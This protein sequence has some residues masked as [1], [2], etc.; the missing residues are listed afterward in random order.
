MVG[1]LSYGAYIPIWRISRD[2]IARASGGPSMGGERSVASW[3]EDSLTMAVEAGLDCLTGIDPKEVDGVYFATVSSPFREKQA[4]SMIATALDLRKDVYTSDFTGSLR[5]GTLAVKSAFDAVKAG[6]A[7]SILVTAADSRVATPTSDLE[8]IFGDGAASLLIGEGE[9]IA[10]IEGFSTT[11]DAIP[12]P[13]KRE[14]DK[15]P[16][17]FEAKMD[18]LT[19]LGDVSGVVNDLMKKCGIET[20]DVS[21]FAYYGPDPRSYM[22]I[23]KSI[24]IEKTQIV[25]P[26]FATVGI[27]GTPHCLLLLVSALENAKAGERIVCASH[28][29]GCDAFS[30][31]TTEKIEEIKGK[32]RGTKVYVSSKKMLP[33]YGRFLDYKGLRE[34]G[35]P[36]EWVKSAIVK[37]W[38]DE[39]WEIPLYGMRCKKCGVLQYPPGRCCMMCG[40]KDNSEDVKLAR[41]GKIFTY[42][43]DYLIG[44]GNMAGDGINPGTRTV[45]DLEDGCR[46]WI[47]M[48]DHFPEEVD[49]DMPVELTFRLFHEKGDFRHYGWRARPVR[50]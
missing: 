7:K 42:V 14:K 23:A 50:G 25:D 29:D 28:G 12:G 32:R 6:T 38:R 16:R 21:K 2:E 37:Y 13:W 30:V 47:E 22:D 15:F 39:K 45:V 18:R 24:K 31:K 8:Q 36:I 10:E 40:E 3:D 41:K 19:L 44:P 46:L 35:W 1:I 49:V 33:S 11:S 4:A 34:T 26:F 20:K 9:T 43:H 48:T 17:I 27:T 5:A